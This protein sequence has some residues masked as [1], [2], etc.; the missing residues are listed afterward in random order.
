MRKV[1]TVVVVAALALVAYQAVTNAAAE[2]PAD[3]TAAEIACRQLGTCTGSE[4]LPVDVRLSPFQRTYGFETGAGAV[5][6][7]CRW[8]YLLW[9]EPQCRA[10][11]A[12]PDQVEAA[13]P[14]RAPHEVPRGAPK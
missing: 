10:E 6:V 13:T 2:H 1:V 9:G 11:V 4:L 7:R 3:A 12:R 14:T 8:P 5:E